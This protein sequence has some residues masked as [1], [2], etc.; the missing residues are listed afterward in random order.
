MSSVGFTPQS[1]DNELEKL[2]AAWRSLNDLLKNL[3]N[4]EACLQ[5][6]DLK[7]TADHLKVAKWNVAQVKKAIAQLG[8]RKPL[9]LVRAAHRRVRSK[10]VLCR[11]ITKLKQRFIN[12]RDCMPQQRLVITDVE[13]E[14]VS[15]H[16]VI[17]DMA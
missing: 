15:R 4:T 12:F 13:I 11:T 7:L 8:K 1:K 9:K 16:E 10:R 3:E 14:F 2:R 17:E 6:H 5:N